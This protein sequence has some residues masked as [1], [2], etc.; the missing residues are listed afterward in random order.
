MQETKKSLKWWFLII[1]IFGLWGIRNIGIIKEDILTGISL[2][3]GAIFGGLFF[4][5]GIKIEEMII[6][7]QKFIINVLFANLGF[8]AVSSLYSFLK[9]FPVA[10][11]IIMVVIEVVITV[12]LIKNVKRLPSIN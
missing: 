1:G 2:L 6:K 3:I 9:G 11:I 8:I 10:M 7:S 12:Y 4:Y 5:I